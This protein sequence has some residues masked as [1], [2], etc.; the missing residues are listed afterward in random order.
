[1]ILNEFIGQKIVQ[2]LFNRI[3][4]ESRLT[5]LK[6]SSSSQSLHVILHSILWDIFFMYPNYI[7]QIISINNYS[8]DNITFGSFTDISNT[9]TCNFGIYLLLFLI[10]NTF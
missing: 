4:V 6:D 3:E 2:L 9:N 1:M 5:A 10:N 8:C 7:S